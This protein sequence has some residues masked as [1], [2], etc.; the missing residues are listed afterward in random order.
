[1][2][3]RQDLILKLKKK[4]TLRLREFYFGLMDISKDW[5]ASRIT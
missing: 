1:M 2:E 4:R 3:P 5:I